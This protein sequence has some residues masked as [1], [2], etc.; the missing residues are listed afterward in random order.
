MTGDIS[1]LSMN[2]RG[3]ASKF[4][5]R[6]VLTWLREQ[7]CSIYCLQDIHCKPD[8]VKVWEA[9]WGLQLIIAPYRSDSRGVAV[10]FNNSFEYKLHEKILHDDGNYIILDLEMGSLRLTLVN[11]YGPNRDDPR[12]YE[13]IRNKIIQIGNSSIIMC[14]DFNL[15]LDQNKDTVGY[16]HRN[17][18]EA[19]QTV[20]D[21]KN[22]MGLV[23]PWRALHL[24]VRR[25]TW[26]G[27]GPTLKQS[28]LDFFLVSQDIFSQVTATDIQAG[29]KTDHSPVTLS[30]K[31]YD[32]L[33]IGRAHV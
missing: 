25:Y 9:E 3:L 31:L 23:D 33:Q 22:D 30:I 8:M 21:I 24:N 13:E 2:V 11:L 26:R 27:V 15:V 4:K 7:K 1:V 14:G 16:L 18:Q 6:D 5:R 10:L 29:Y 17:N 32:H 28:R 19:Q 12:F 20:L